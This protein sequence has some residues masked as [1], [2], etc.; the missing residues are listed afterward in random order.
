MSD[1]QQ[2][3]AATDR[4]ELD[5]TR[6]VNYAQG[7]VLGADDFHQE[8][9][10]LAGHDQ[11]AARAVAGYGAVRGLRVLAPPA[12]D[13]HEVI[14]RPGEAV[15]PRGRVVRVPDERYASLGAWVAANGAA[16]DAEEERGAVLEGRV[17]LRV[18][19]GYR[20][21]LTDPV[22]VPGEPCRTE[23]DS[24]QPSRIADHF[25]LRLATAAP[26]QAEEQALRALS[27]WLASHVLVA[28]DGTEATLAGALTE[29]RAA[30][31]AGGDFPAHAAVDD[32]AAE[33]PG[34]PTGGTFRVHPDHVAGFLER[35]LRLWVT[36][37]RPRW[38]VDPFPRPAPAPA[39][40]EDD[41]L[42]ATLSVAVK[43][44]ESGAWEL[45][46]S[47]SPVCTVDDAAGPYLAHLRLLQSVLLRP[48]PRELS[49]HGD[50]T[51]LLGLTV[52]ERI[53]GV[54]VAVGAA[55]GNLLQCEPL[56]DDKV[57][58]APVPPSSVPV[59][60]EVVGTLGATQ[61]DRLL[62]RQVT[63]AWPAADGV[64]GL[65]AD[66]WTP[67][68]LNGDVS[69]P[70]GT[71]TVTALRGQALADVAPTTP[72]EV[73]T[74]DGATWKPQ[75][76]APPAITGD[77][78]LASGP[79][80]DGYDVL[81]ATVSGLLGREIVAPVAGLPDGA[82]PRYQLGS[83]KWVLEVPAAAGVARPE[84]TALYKI[85]AAGVIPLTA[86]PPGAT[87][88]EGAPALRVT[89]ARAVTTPLGV[90]RLVEFTFDGYA[91]IITESG[92]VLAQ[93]DRRRRFVVKATPLAPDYTSLYSALY[94][95]LPGLA[96]PPE[97]ADTVGDWVT[98]CAPE[99]GTLGPVSVG[100][101]YF[102]PVGVVLRVTSTANAAALDATRLMVEVSACPDF[103]AV[104]FTP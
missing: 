72:G 13:A 65:V 75:A 10:Y 96:A 12:G 39:A 76:P 59:A 28:E 53:Q 73:L 89:A 40:A 51:G 41:V 60:G 80:G 66:T 48:L 58:W 78:A 35:A 15:T 103:A 3:D 69:G 38:H 100:V 93:E 37:L 95:A 31:Y 32:G 92:S 30:A 23:D 36:E 14:V 67:V 86:P 6:H 26:A 33:P 27:Q 11:Q 91:D 70:P 34:A 55:P 5:P 85:V 24:L 1:F 20:E 7:M 74:F 102:S 50:V 2:R 43:R 19:L 62:N 57:Q 64:L 81:T 4:T 90:V 56:G 42:L 61:V 63:N 9:A 83:D 82:V 98:A 49:A 54:P 22:P 88:G 44:S 8:F 25:E 84:G 87:A 77:V 68:V 17:T 21:R 71:L 46:A 79:G 94:S 16:V 47:A 104:P 97:G 52:V 45:N 99:W 101:E 18:L 29:L